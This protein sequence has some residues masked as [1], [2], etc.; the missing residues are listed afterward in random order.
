MEWYQ[1]SNENVADSPSLLIY[2]ERAQRNI[3]QMIA[4]AG[5][6]ERLF[7]HVKTNKMAEII[8]M[9]IQAGITKF[10]CATIAEAELVAIS[11]EKS[12]KIASF[13]ILIA[14]QLVSPKIERLINLKKKYPTHTFSSLIDCFDIANETNQIF[15]KNDLIANIYLDLN[16]GMNRSGHPLNDEALELYE[17]LCQQSNLACKGV[18]VYDGHL[19]EPDFNQRKIEIDSDFVAVN[20]FLDKIKKKKLPKP[21]VIAGGTPAFT[22][23]A[24]REDTFCSPGTCVLWDWGYGDKLTEQ[25]F[26]Y[27]ALILTRVI[28]KPK[29]GIITIDM[30]HK[31]VASENPIDK[32]IHFLNLTNYELLS[33]SEEHGV[34]KVKDW[35]NIK[36]GKVLYGVPYHVCPTVNLY[37]E[38]YWV[39]SQEI[40]GVWQVLGRRRRI[41]M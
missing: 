13:Q 12:K 20:D 23:H 9:M 16:N 38:A 40:K 25:N 14:H 36:V 17:F 5:S 1:L 28:S 34:L 21:Q 22:S 3:E 33:Q 29:E 6:A 8:V 27:A 37:E 7:T 26:E 32:R 2:K 19:R 30:G 18:H 15:K 11:I 10:K 24:L 35:E 41:E 39:E 4:I 31:A